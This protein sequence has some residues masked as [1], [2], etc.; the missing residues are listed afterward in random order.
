MGS[1]ADASGLKRVGVPS[2]LSDQTLWL[3]QIA[4]VLNNVLV[5]KLLATGTVT[6]TQNAASTSL[7][8]PRIG[9]SSFIQ[10]MPTTAN[11]AA[12]IGAGTLYVSARTE[13]VATLTHA[14]NAQT[15][16]SYTFLVIG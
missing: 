12:E 1:L 10:F 6:L 8:D 14:N 5:G 13:G 3:R 7:Q 4:N 16:R 15:D 2:S 9:V 11:A